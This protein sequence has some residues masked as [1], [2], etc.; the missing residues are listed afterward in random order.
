MIQV[1]RGYQWRATVPGEVVLVVEIDRV[2]RI[3]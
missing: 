3:V 2:E 1:N